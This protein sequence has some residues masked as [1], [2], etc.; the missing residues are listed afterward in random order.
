MKREPKFFL[1]LPIHNT[2]EEYQAYRKFVTNSVVESDRERLPLFYPTFLVCMII[3]LFVF[4]IY[5]L[6]NS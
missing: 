3:G 2:A 6:V 1:Q 4:L 5:E